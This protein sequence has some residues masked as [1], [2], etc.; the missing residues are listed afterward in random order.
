MAFLGWK[1]NVKNEKTKF[2]TEW[3]FNLIT[4]RLKSEIF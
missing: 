1:L 3:I 2:F 4:A